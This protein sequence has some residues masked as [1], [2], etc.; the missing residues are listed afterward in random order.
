LTIKD[1]HGLEGPSKQG[2]GQPGLADVGTLS[3]GFLFPNP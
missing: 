1:G 3:I 2:C